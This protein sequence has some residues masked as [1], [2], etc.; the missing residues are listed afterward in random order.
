MSTRKNLPKELQALIS[1]SVELLGRAIK[2][3]YGSTTYN[4]VEK[5]RQTMKGLRGASPD[6]V[7]DVLLK[8]KKQLGRRTDV[9]LSQLTNSYTL[10]LELINRCETAYRTYRLQGLEVDVPKQ[11]PYGIIFVLTAHPTEAR[12]PEL[13]NIF[14]SIQ[15]LLV[16]C[17][18]ESQE[19]WKEEL[20]HLLLLTL[21]ISLARDTKPAVRDE[22]ENIYSY[23]LRED[24][25]N[26]IISFARR[27]VNVYFRAW[28]GGDKDGHP[29]VDEKTLVESLNLSRS[30]L[31]AFLEK[32]IRR[33]H[34]LAQLL[35]DKQSRSVGDRLT[36]LLKML[37]GLAKLK[38]GDGHTMKQFRQYLN[39]TAARYE[40][41]VGVKSPELEEV[42]Q[43]VWIFP[44]LVV[45]IEIREDSAVVGNALDAQK[46][47]PIECMLQTLK[48]VCRGY[49]AR[50]YVRGFIL[51]MVETFQ[52]LLNGVTLV[53]RVFNKLE[54]PVVPLFENELALSTC[55]TI[56]NEAFNRRK[57]IVSNHRRIWGSRFEVMVGYS[58]SSKES[59]V[60]P[61][62]LLIAQAMSA[63][64]RTLKKHGLTPVFFHGSGGSVERGGGSIREQ[65]EWWPRSAVHIFK[66]T[67]QGEMVARNFANQNIFS[68]QIQRILELFHTKNGAR[69]RQKPS[70]TVDRFS[71]LIKARYSSMVN[72]DNFFDVIEKATP[73][74][75]LHHLK[76]GSRPTKRS[77]GG[78][79]RKLR[80]IPW[81]LCWTQTRV[82]FPTWWGVGSSW[83]QLT[84]AEKKELQQ[85]FQS[86]G[87]LRSFVKVLGFTLAKVELG[88]WRLYLHQSELSQE[89]QQDIYAEFVR[90][91]N[92][93]VTFF[94]EITQEDNFLWFRPWLQQSIEYRSSMIHPLNI[95]Q[96]ESLRREDPNLLRDTVTGIACGML[97]TG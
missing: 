65:T 63:L 28:V 75:F 37:E 88:V 62:R 93:T 69:P 89:V 45:P 2:D 8:E 84:N 87:L 76:I 4:Q 96:L 34:H 67:T 80:A 94:K 85:A 61:S 92:Q 7:F 79:K 11:R 74:S 39:Q 95:I 70:P 19:K 29:G 90:E 26:S 21:K 53:T 14:E 71:D 59:G 15:Q 27:G 73:Y 20:Y 64:E 41:V 66:A 56:L 72:D 36:K 49:E 81:I 48:T 86:N 9:F 32:K 57:S 23:I 22:A 83:N 47:M 68:R 5:I 82:L 60:F 24:I 46:T 38:D 58:D 1:W 18:N 16:N 6:K 3:E 52:D 50:W 31:T 97:T 44:A 25:L 17:L 78:E 91:F 40:R 33:C 13:L 55:T 54:I 10:M 35:S 51:S 77:T 30:Y 43:L 42:L 12:S